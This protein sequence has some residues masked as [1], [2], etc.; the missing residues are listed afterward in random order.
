MENVDNQLMT[1]ENRLQSLTDKELLL[2]VQ[3]LFQREKRLGDA[4]LLGLKE[5]KARRV[6]AALGYPSLFEFLVKHFGLSESA[7]YQRWQALKLIEAVPEVQGDLF[8]GTL[9]L[10]NAALV[11]SFIQNQEKQ[12]PLNLEAK[13]EFI[14]SVKGKTHRDAKLVLAEKDPAAALPPTRE[15]PITPTYTQLQIT[16][17]QV[18][19]VALQEV[20]E[21]LSHTVPDGNLNDVL[22]YMLQLTSTTLKKRMGRTE[23]RESKISERDHQENRI[24]RPIRSLALSGTDK[25]KECGRSRYIPVEIKRRVFAR[26]G[27]CCEYT[28]EGGKRCESRHQLEIDHDLPWS[29]G[30]THEVGRLKLLCRS[31]NLYC[32]K[33]THGYWYKPK[34]QTKSNA[35]ANE[36]SHSK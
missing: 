5:I 34:L 9:S 6:F 15:K 13:K 7:T 19:M 4:I 21:L 17:D 27:G 29:Q 12:Q 26:A 28:S 8:N 22:K 25:K 23:P 3:N 2:Q 16:V 10:S 31:H 24:K 11:Q 18:T 36:A 32:T 1:F 20:K 14:E 35:K 30:G 33:E